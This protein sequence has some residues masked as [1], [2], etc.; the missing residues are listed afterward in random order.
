MIMGMGELK[1]I[2][3][4][5]IGYH[6]GLANIKSYIYIMINFSTCFVCVVN[7]EP[8]R[9]NVE[10]ESVVAAKGKV[11]G[12]RDKLIIYIYV[13]ME[14]RIFDLILIL[15]Q[16]LPLTLPF[17]FKQTT[18]FFLLSICKNAAAIHQIVRKTTLF[19]FFVGNTSIYNFELSLLIVLFYDFGF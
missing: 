4:Q 12:N 11:K 13:W 9:C 19:F 18:I 2:H 6:Q 8:S 3:K 10:A 15:F 1:A 17:H 5:G 7:V 16:Y 14:V